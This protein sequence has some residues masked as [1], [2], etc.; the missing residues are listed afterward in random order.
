MADVQSRGGSSAGGDRQSSAGGVSMELEHA[1]GFN[2]NCVNALHAHPNGHD[3]VYAA[4]GCVVISDLADP[5]NQVFLRGHDQNVSCV[6]LSPSG[7]FIASGQTGDN[8]DVLVW[9]FDQKKMIYRMTS[10]DHGIATVAFSHD[11]RLLLTVGDNTDKRLMVWDMASGL[12]NAQGTAMPSA[13]TCSAWGGFEKDVKR[14]PTSNYMFVTAG[15][16]AAVMWS[17]DP[18]TGTLNPTKFNLGPHQREF[19]CV[20]ISSDGEW[21]Y[22]GSS[23]GDVS[24]LQVKNKVMSKVYNVA[25]G[26]VHAIACVRQGPSD[27]IICGGGDGGVTVMVGEGKDLEDIRNGSCHLDGAVT[28][29]SSADGAL[30]LCGT[31]QSSIYRVQFP[32]MVPRLVS[33]NHSLWVTAVAFPG[34]VSDR[35]GTCSDDCT[36]RMWDLSDYTTIVKATARDGGTPMCLDFGIECAV[37]GWTDGKMRCFDTETGELLWTIPNAHRGGVASLAVSHNARFIVSGGEEGDVR[38][39]DIKSKELVCHLKEH[40][41]RVTAVKIFPDDTMALTASKDRAVLCWDLRREKRVANFTQRMGGIFGMDL[42]PSAAQFMTVGQEKK[43]TYWDMRQP[44]P[45]QMIHKAHTE[46]ATCLAISHDGTLFATG[47]TDQLVKLWHFATGS[48]ILDGVGHSGTVTGVVFS[49]DDKQLVSA[50][51]DGCVYIWNIYT[52]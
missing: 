26:G 16:R 50:G 47:G 18:V 51:E 30:V 44:Q 22:I 19:T 42:H 49:H 25:Q 43:I 24:C 3:A 14:R 17:L 8:A 11:E 21:V 48:L 45:I 29:L 23:T 6:A 12:L 2:G 7:R 39:W 9:D 13:T 10:H 31:G 37:T 20:A 27:A 28:S 38:V 36:V 32:E 35:F 46:E 40:M 1:M 41:V 52:S 34:G 33:E 4:G 15:S 5:H